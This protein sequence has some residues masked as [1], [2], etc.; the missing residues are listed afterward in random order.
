MPAI[1]PERT[2]DVAATNP[3]R[4]GWLRLLWLLPLLAVIAVAGWVSTERSEEDALLRQARRDLD[5]GKA[6]R[7]EASLARLVRKP[8]LSR[9]AR[10]GGAE[11]FFRLGED[12]AANALLKGAR[13][14]PKDPRDRMLQG[15]AASCQRAALLLSQADRAKDPLARLDLARQALT[16][17]PEAPLV[18]RRVVEEEL[19][20]MSR[21]EDP[22][23]VKQ[24]EMDYLKLRQGTPRLASDVKQRLA[25]SLGERAN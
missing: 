21:R 20:V 9:E 13:P 15:L 3:S 11:L 25:D 24:F 16:E 18:L 17:T 10:W 5:A 14:D 4:R 12:H 1:S 19:L 2:P 22:R 6:E 23:V 7:A 8:Y